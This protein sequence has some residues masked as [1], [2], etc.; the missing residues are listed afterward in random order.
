MAIGTRRCCFRRTCAS[1][2]LK[3]IWCISFSMQWSSW[4]GAAR[5]NERGGG[6]AQYPPSLLLGLLNYSYAT[7]TFG[8]RR[9]EQSTYE[10]GAVCVLTADTHP[11]HDRRVSPRQQG[12]APRE[13]PAGAGAGAGA[14]AGP[15]RA[16]HRDHRRRQGGGQRE[17]ACGG[18]LPARRRDDCPTGVGGAAVA[19]Q[20]R[21]G[22][23]DALQDGLGTPE[24]I[25][26]REKR[27]A[28][29]AQARAA[30]EARAH[31]RYAAELAGHA[32]KLAER[33]ARR[34][35]GEKVGRA[36]HT[37][38]ALSPLAKRSSP[39]RQAGS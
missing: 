36:S 5:V 13:F 20:G 29:L 10:N 8:S 28:A 31:V 9:I 19:R 34:Q 18:E 3:N 35:R 22:R 17:Q 1:G 23:R 2:C 39:T 37:T 32:A 11:D 6:S 38:S 15:V 26:R 33:R 14:E 16:N 27:Q 4:I 24:E 12:T 30:I 25:V 7:G 21:A